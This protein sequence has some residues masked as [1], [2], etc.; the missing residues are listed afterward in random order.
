MSND[1][2]KTQ[3]FELIKKIAKKKIVTVGKNPIGKDKF[4]APPRRSKF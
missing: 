2:V 4:E 3:V 1:K